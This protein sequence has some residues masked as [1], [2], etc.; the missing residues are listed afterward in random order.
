MEFEKA[1]IAEEKAASKKVK[2]VRMIDDNVSVCSNDIFSSNNHSVI[3]GKEKRIL[4]NKVQSYKELFKEELKGFKIKK[5][6]STEELKEYIAEMDCIIE[7]G[8]VETFMSDSIY[9]CIYR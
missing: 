8:T 3:I 1:K 5:N 9:S 4:L 6:C 7:T 2:P